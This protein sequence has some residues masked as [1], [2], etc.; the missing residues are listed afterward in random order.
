MISQ[1]F[2]LIKYICLSISGLLILLF[3]CS[4]QSLAANIILESHQLQY[5]EDSTRKLELNDVLNSKQFKAVK[6]LPFNYGFTASAIWIKLSL[7]PQQQQLDWLEIGF[8]QLDSVNVYIQD[9]HSWKEYISGDLQPFHSKLVKY[10]DFAFPLQPSPTIYIRSV[11]STAM[12]IP[13]NLHT[14][15]TLIEKQNQQKFL[16]GILFGIFL[17]LFVYNFILFFFLKDYNYLRYITFLFFYALSQA[18][19]TGVAYQYLWPNYPGFNFYALALSSILVTASRLNFIYFF[20]Q[21][22]RYAPLASKL[23]IFFGGV[24]IAIFAVARTIFSTLN[25]GFITIALVS[26]IGMNICILICGIQ[27]YKKGYQPAKYFLIA[28]SMVPLGVLLFI[29]NRLGIFSITFI[30]D[31]GFILSGAFEAILLAIALAK[32]IDLLNQEV[33]SSH[34]HLL[35]SNLYLQQEIAQRITVEQELQDHKNHLT[36]LVQ[37]RTQELFESNQQLIEAKEHAEKA[38]YTKSLFLANMSH[39]LRTPLN[40]IIGYS[41][42]LTEELI[43]SVEPIHIN[44]LKNIEQSGNHLLQLVND[45]LDLSK[46]EANK[47]ELEKTELIISDLLLS[48]ST[49]CQPLI[50]KNNNQFTIQQEDNLAVIYTDPLRLK[51]ILF[52]LISNAAKFTSEGQIELIIKCPAHLA[53]NTMI[54]QVRDTGIGIP[55]DK[56]DLLFK[57]FSQV[58]NTSTRNYEGT[59]LGLALSR[60]LALLMGGDITVESQINQGSTFELSLPLK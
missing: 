19:L 14:S 40:A 3:G 20:I 17:G 13:I 43:N 7:T 54:F 29:L 30:S 60:E 2:S 26:V 25:P 11:T 46:I 33:E 52:N 36:D 16:L 44:D 12:Q 35:Q 57:K 42:L 5:L 53:Q 47:I 51:Q 58:D 59:G 39:E 23:M 4:T 24:T 45:I 6:A 31:Y 27:S 49:I 37:E 55:P 1:N 9:G 18:N 48:L 34:A 10:P 21:T 15:H 50:D 41:Q 56:Q 8:P 32:R 22:P 38:N 28:W